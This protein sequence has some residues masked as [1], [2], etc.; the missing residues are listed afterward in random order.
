MQNQMNLMDKYSQGPTTN[1]SPTKQRTPEHPLRGDSRLMN[2][3]ASLR[4]R[5]ED[6]VPGKNFKMMAN[7]A[8]VEIAEL[9][10]ALA[11]AEYLLAKNMQEKEELMTKEAE[12]QF[13][14][15]GI[16]DK[17]RDCDGLRKKAEGT[18]QDLNGK[19]KQTETSKELV[20]KLS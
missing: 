2:Q 15:K 4:V 20:S 1:E 19:L 9:K 6:T 8:H 16:E 12:H 5:M 3:A 7:V 13:V 10:D 14:V 11:Y 18:I 17:Y